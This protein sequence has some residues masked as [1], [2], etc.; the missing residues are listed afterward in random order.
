MR[1]CATGREV[2]FGAALLAFVVI[3]AWTAAFVGLFLVLLSKAGLLRVDELAETRGLD[4]IAN[5]II[6]RVRRNTYLVEMVYSAGARCL[7]LL[8]ARVAASGA[9]Q[10]L[11]HGATCVLGVLAVADRRLRAWPRVV[12]LPQALLWL[13]VVRHA[14]DRELCRRAGRSV[15]FAMRR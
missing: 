10:R 8:T 12:V 2:Y 13:R 9:V 14:T 1:A 3:V 11:G 5:P 4:T 6:E 7:V 15:V